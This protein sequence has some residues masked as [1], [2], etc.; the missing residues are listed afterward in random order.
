M[1][2]IVDKLLLFLL[3]KILHEKDLVIFVKFVLKK[4]KITINCIIFIGEIFF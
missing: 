4:K 2:I 3:L 1:S